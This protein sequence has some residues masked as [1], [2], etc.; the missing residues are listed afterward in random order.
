MADGVHD[1]TLT[2]LAY[3]GAAL[4]HLDDGRAAFVPFGLPGERVRVRLSEDRGRFVR[5]KLMEVLEAAP[6]RIRPRCKH[7]GACGGCHYQHMPYEAQLV[8]K[9][10]ILRD[11]LVRIGHIEA[12]TVQP[13]APSPNPWNYRNHVQFHLTPEG[14]V[15]YAG[16]REGVDMAREIIP[17]EE[18]FLPQESINDLWPQLKF[19]DSPD[20]ERVSIRAGSQD[21]LL[22]ILDGKS[23]EAPELDIEADVSV[24]HLFEGDSLV[25]AGE[26]HVMIRV[27]GRDFRVSAASFF[28]V[29]TAVAEMMAQHV[30]KHLSP[31]LGTVLDVYCGVGL[32]SAFLAQRC[33]RLIGVESSASAC[34]DFTANLDEYDNVEL[35]EDLAERVLPALDVKPDLILVDPPRAGLERAALDAILEMEPGR[36]IYVSCDPATLARDARLLIQG[37]YRIGQVTPFDLFPQTYHIESI[38]SFER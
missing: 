35:Y 5:G 22:L 27:L 15:G 29:N 23:R 3:G 14:K 2:A 9:R 21:E 19:E 32:F 18:C 28:Q 12:P 1:L 30:L 10:E 7:F 16:L 24:A 8:A 13:T 37:G 25:L 26:D 38:I 17:I 6:Q 20:I 31:H 34:A 36:I 4:G 33:E 11:Q